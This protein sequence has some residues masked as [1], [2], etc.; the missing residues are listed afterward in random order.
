MEAIVEQLTYGNFATVCHWRA[1]F[2]E[3]VKISLFLVSH[4]AENL[5]ASAACIRMVLIT[6][7]WL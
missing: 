7:C 4:V 2:F 5:G 3:V 6:C 1:I